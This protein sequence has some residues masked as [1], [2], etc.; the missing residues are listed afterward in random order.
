MLE[1]AVLAAAR[2]GQMDRAKK[3]FIKYAKAN[4]LPNFSASRMPASDPDE[5]LQIVT[6]FIKD[7]L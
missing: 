3:I 1:H 4:P 5:F 2:T 6:Q 7:G